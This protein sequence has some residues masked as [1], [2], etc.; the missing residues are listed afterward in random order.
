VE[1][2]VVPQEAKQK[3][4]GLGVFSNFDRLIF[5]GKKEPIT[6]SVHRCVVTWFLYQLAE[7]LSLVL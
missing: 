6:I 2:C 1:G 7:V 5:G 4:I 3:V